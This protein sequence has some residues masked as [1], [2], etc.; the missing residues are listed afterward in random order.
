MKEVNMSEWMQELFGV[1][2]PVIGMCH[3]HPLPGDPKYEAQKGLEWVYDRALDDLRALQAGGVDA[4]MFSNEFSLPYLT[5]VETVT[6]ASMARVIAELKADINITLGVNVLWD[7]AASLDLAVATDA[8]FVREI[9]TG[10]YASD[11]GLSGTSMR[12]ALKMCAYYS[13][14]YL[15]LPVIWPSVMLLIS[16][17]RPCLTPTRMR[18][19]FLD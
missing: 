17:A 13:I 7:P 19:A 9:F 1:K 14:S 10:V 6:V 8:K 2:K 11:Y 4:V 3:L 16:P 18:C 12:S 5:K 15:N